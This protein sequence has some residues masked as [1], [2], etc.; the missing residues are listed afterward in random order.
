MMKRDA[1]LSTALE[2]PCDIY[3]ILQTR[4]SRFDIAQAESLLAILQQRGFLMRS[5][6]DFDGR[7]ERQDCVDSDHILF[8]QTVWCG[9]VRRR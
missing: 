2:Q 4:V 5:A 6:T 3:M 7:F 8:R 1:A 9:S